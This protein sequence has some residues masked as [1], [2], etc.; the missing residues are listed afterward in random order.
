LKAYRQPDGGVK[1]FRPSANARRFQRSAERL[2]LP[3]LPEELFIQAIEEI[4]RIDRAWVPDRFEQSLYLRPFMFASDV[5]LGVRPAAEVTFLL[6]ASPAGA[7]FP[8]GVKPVSLWLS[9]EYTRAA[10]GGTGAAKCGGNY[11]ASLLAQQEGIEHGCQQVVFLDAVEQRW[12]EELG[13]MNIGLVFDDGTIVTPE[14]NGSILQGVTRESILRLADDRGYKVD[15]RRISIDE[16]RD[17]VASGRI[18]EVFACGTAAVMTP[19]GLLKWRGGELA[20]GTGEPGPVTSE[21]RT[22]LM[23][24]QYGLAEDT[25]GWMH[26]I[27]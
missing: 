9:E 20:M 12:L 22:A 21:L 13:G 2:A 10:P 16:W 27:R 7:Y 5:F 24:I 3:E 8:H 4:V 19:V 23:E 11:A 6:I 15:E 26:E 14:L 1:V 17:G 18:T 25:Y